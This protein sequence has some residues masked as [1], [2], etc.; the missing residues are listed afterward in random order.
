M[1]SQQ[2]PLSSNSHQATAKPTPSQA[3]KPMPQG[4]L[5]APTSPDE[6]IKVTSKPDKTRQNPT[7]DSPVPQDPATTPDEMEAYELRREE[8]FRSADE[9][10]FKE[11]VA[12]ASLRRAAELAG[13]S[14]RTAQR[15][16]ADPDFRARVQEERE[17]VHCEVVGKLTMLMTEALEAMKSALNDDNTRLRLSAARSVLKFGHQFAIQTAEIG[18]LEQTLARLENQDNAKDER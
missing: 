13:V 2:K 7:E 17:Q 10:L 6:Q 14:E 16:W 9:R 3:A 5:G 18:K 12:G 1:S 4:S 8:H 15:R 11:I